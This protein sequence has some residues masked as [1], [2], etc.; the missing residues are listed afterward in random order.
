MRYWCSEGCGFV[1]SNHRCE[2]W[3]NLT[4][5]N[6]EAEEALKAEERTRIMETLREKIET[7]RDYHRGKFAENAGLLFAFQK[8][9]DIIKAIEGES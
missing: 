2:Q 4:W 1:E 9:L 5:I 3:T 6:S 8:C 7:A